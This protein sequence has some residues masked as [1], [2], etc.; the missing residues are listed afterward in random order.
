[1]KARY[2]DPALGRFAS[3]DINHDGIN[4]FAYCDNNP[5]NRIDQDGKLSQSQWTEIIRFGGPLLLLYA[6][7]LIT[8]GCAGI[9]AGM[10]VIRYGE[11]ISALGD[12]ASAI[13]PAAG[14][15]IMLYGAGIQIAGAG[16]AI[17]SAASV[18]LGLTVL[19]M[20]WYC[21]IN[22]DD[23]SSADANYYASL[24]TKS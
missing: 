8:V 2:Y 6:W 18:A 16:S 21:L 24:L 3:E 15:T 12:A 23:V 7:E 1:M 19:S 4:W 20:A 9:S 10:A 17:G 14:G 5:V 11:A 22:A 13:S